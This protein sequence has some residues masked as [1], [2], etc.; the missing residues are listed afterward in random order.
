MMN[1]FKTGDIC[2]IKDI[3]AKTMELYKIKSTIHDFLICPCHIPRSQSLVIASILSPTIAMVH[4]NGD[5]TKVS[6]FYLTDLEK[7]TIKK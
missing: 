4:Y 5:T 1:G 7:A 3:S 6:I 2:F